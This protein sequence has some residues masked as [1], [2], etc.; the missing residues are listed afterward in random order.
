MTRSFNVNSC[1]HGRRS[2]LAASR[3]GTAHLFWRVWGL[4]GSRAIY[5]QIKVI[6][7]IPK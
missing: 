5:G 6:G 2:K 7:F 4:R 1:W 3:A